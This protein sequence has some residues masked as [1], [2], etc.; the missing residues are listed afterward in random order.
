MRNNHT[1][2][3]LIYSCEFIWG[4]WQELQ[5]LKKSSWE[6][7]EHLQTPHSCGSALTTE[8]LVA[9]G[10]SL[11]SYC[12]RNVFWRWVTRTSRQPS[13]S[14]ETTRTVSWYHTEWSYYSEPQGFTQNSPNVPFRPQ[15]KQDLSHQRHDLQKF[16]CTLIYV[17]EKRKLKTTERLSPTEVGTSGEKGYSHIFLQVSSGFDPFYKC[18]FMQQLN[19]II[20]EKSVAAWSWCECLLWWDHVCWKHQ[21]LEK[22]L[23]VSKVLIV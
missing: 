10:F 1:T 11:C 6:S 4:L 13:C 17:G 20:S 2:Q 7:W 8:D 22:V 5:K 21:N 15:N 14:T 3:N 12:K 16:L 19:N 18:N 23:K 9:C